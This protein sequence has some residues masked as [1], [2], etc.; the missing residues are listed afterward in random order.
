MGGSC[1]NSC[2]TTRK[3]E[4]QVS[5][6][7]LACS[8]KPNLRVLCL[9]SSIIIEQ[10]EVEVRS[11]FELHRNASLELL[12]L[13]KASI[14]STA[15]LDGSG[16]RLVTDLSF[17]PAGVRQTKHQ[18][19]FGIDFEF[20]IQRHQGDSATGEEMVTVQCTFEATY[21]LKPKFVAK[22]EQIEAFHLGNA[23]FNCW[24]FFREFIQNT[25]V[26]L[27]YP[28]PPVPF[29]RLQPKPT[30]KVEPTVMQQKTAKHK[31]PRRRKEKT[32]DKSEKLVELRKS[33]RNLRSST[34]CCFYTQ[35]RVFRR[36][37]QAKL[38]EVQEPS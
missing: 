1:S 16:N 13:A 26:R 3:D 17:K 33:G 38:V 5:S 21:A 30:K 27:N 36:E 7:A 8:F 29:L 11:A 6:C 10:D 9:M 12:R 23:V 24:P 18:L 4:I 28:P 15:D 31:A 32:S 22:A 34:G 2:P 37:A 35:A 20:K 25:V 14:V 19:V